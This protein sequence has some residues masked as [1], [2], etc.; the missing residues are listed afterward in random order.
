VLSRVP[1]RHDVQSVECGCA[2]LPFAMSAHPPK[3]LVLYSFPSSDELTAGL[4]AFVLK[5]QKEA[6]EKKGRFT[7]AL[8]GGSLPKTLAALIGNPAV[9]WDKWYADSHTRVSVVLMRVG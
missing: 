3:D 9:K 1:G 7:V 8:S 6:V 2:K 5:A 4:A